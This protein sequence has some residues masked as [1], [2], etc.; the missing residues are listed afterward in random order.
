MEFIQIIL[1][2]SKLVEAKLYDAAQK[3]ASNPEI[4]I[5]IHNKAA[6]HVIK[7]CANVAVNYLPHMAFG[8]YEN[9]FKALK[10]KIKKK[11]IQEFVQQAKTSVPL[12]QL[13]N[14][15]L[16]KAEELN[17]NSSKLSVTEVDKIKNSSDPYGDYGLELPSSSVSQKPSNGPLEILYAAFEAN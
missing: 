10:D 13:L 11:Q 8:S 16:L 2:N 9:P 1:Q 15:I 5:T 3:A 4:G 6:Y 7:D 12:T 17:L 14:L